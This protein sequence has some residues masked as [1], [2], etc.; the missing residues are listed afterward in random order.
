MSSNK[1]TKCALA[2]KM[3]LM[4]GAFGLS[5]PVMANDGAT[6]E[7]VEV[8]QIRGIRASQEA[9]LNA[10]RFSGAVV[11][12]V[13]AEDIGKFPDKNVA[14]SLSRI[15]GVSVTRGF[16]EGEKIAV[17]GT[18]PAQNRT[19]LNG[20]SVASADWFVLD[21][22]SRA[23][24]FT[25]LPSNVVSDLEVYKT[26]QADIQ[27]GSLGGTVYLKTRKPLDLDANTISLQVQGQYS[28][29]SKEWDPQLSGLYSWKNADE[30]F[31]LLVSLTRQERS[32]A[33]KG[34]E[35]LG[36]DRQEVD[37]EDYWAPRII[38]NAY[39][40]QERKRTTA[41]V[42]A[43]WRPTAQT[44]VVLNVLDTKLDANNINHNL[45]TFFN[46]G[47]VEDSAVISGSGIVAGQVNN[48]SSEFAIID[49]ISYSDA[50]SYDLEINHELPS[51]V[52]ITGKLGTTKAEGGTSRDRYHQFNGSYVSSSYDSGL[53]LSNYV[54]AGNLE[55]FA[56]IEN[57]TLDWMQEGSRLMTD[58]EN[59]AGLDLQ[60][61]IDHGIFH[62]LK[63]GTLVQDHDKSQRQDGTRF[64]WLADS[65]H[66]DPINGP[67]GDV[68]AGQGSWG[69]AAMGW[70][71]NPIPFSSFASGDSYAFY[72]LMSRAKS[73]ELAFPAQA[74]DSPTA[75]FL[76][77]P[78]TW[79]VNEKIWAG[80]AKADF[81]SDRVRGDVG[82]RVVKT[83]VSSSGYSWNGDWVAAS[84]NMVGGY[85]ILA[86]ELEPSQGGDW[87]VAYDT[88][89]HSYTD[90]LPNIN[91]VFDLS[92]DSLVRFSA[93]RVMSRPDYVNIANQ[94]SVNI[95]TR[96]G[97]RGNP[98][99]EPVRANQFDLSYEWY[100]NSSSLIA[101]TYFHKD[102]QGSV[103]NSVTREMAFDEANNEMVEVTITE[104]KNGLGGRVQG[105]EVS[106]QQ[107]FGYFGFITNYTYTDA[108]SDQ[109]RDAV[110][111]PG[112]GLIAG[113]S[114]HMANLTGYFENDMFS[115]RLS[116]NYR[117][118]FFNGVGEFGNE[119]Y[120]DA[121][122]QLDASL[123][124]NFNDNVSFVVE[125]VNLL[126]ED[127]YQYHIDK[128]RPAS[129]YQNGRRFTA[130]VNVRF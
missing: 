83:D 107:A 66:N 45:Y 44:D 105:L 81:S 69:A 38:G 57:R 61:D 93:A 19:L 122:G 40:Q 127:L 126:D 78:N 9:N 1:I 47:F 75:T 74:Y 113:N 20:A 94:Q 63:V 6:D 79:E 67:Y 8:I 95:P 12:V 90:V 84:V 7:N 21:N 104:P 128:T 64:H 41:L 97:N 46:S 29:V 82:V 24:N 25:L 124:Y 71:G 42:T 85:A 103:L 70:T 55:T 35:V 106:Y 102:I 73:A 56:D 114:R 10:K 30:T 100:F 92:D 72:P 91:V 13:T 99:L 50:K 62:T 112:S 98:F 31:G 68:R 65:Q 59:Y 123:T 101:F 110:N 37:G 121:F 22:P 96:S 118:E 53:N 117:T 16:G 76:F 120:T 14:E 27:E 87:G 80:Y 23:F 60:F 58:K 4:V 129:L 115:A 3:G 28:D 18:D 49:R 5:M 26:P 36:F 77:L 88:L 51:G 39:F 11:D 89:K 34:K 119:V 17:R 108:K 116:Y 15:T 125:A 111:N 48:A 109:D 43:Q 32:L 86:N 2:V 54:T 130:G 52:I 33:R